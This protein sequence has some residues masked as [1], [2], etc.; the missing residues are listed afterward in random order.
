MSRNKRGIVT[1]Q[2]QLRKDILAGKMN[3]ICTRCMEMER[4]N[5]ST[6]RQWSNKHPNHWD[7]VESTNED[8]STTR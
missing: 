5:I 3:K 4:N 1:Q 7:V 2:K 8:G 6:T